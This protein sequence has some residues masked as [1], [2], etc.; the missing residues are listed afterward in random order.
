[1]TPAYLILLLNAAVFGLYGL[2]FLFWPSAMAVWVTDAAPL[3]SSG[4]I[5]LR[6]TYGGMSLAVGGV[7]YLLARSPAHRRLGLQSVLLLMVC[8]AGGRLVG[9]LTDGDA[10]DT[11]ELYLALELFMAAVAGLALKSR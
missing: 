7:L 6:A 8:M 1:M 2:A 3:S 10:N 4:V 11:M 9:M 5:D